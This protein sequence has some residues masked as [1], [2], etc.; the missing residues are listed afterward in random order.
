MNDIVC[1][2]CGGDVMHPIDDECPQCGVAPRFYCLDWRGTPLPFFHPRRIEASHIRLQHKMLHARFVDRH[3]VSFFRDIGYGF[4]TWLIAEVDPPQPSTL[5]GVDLDRA[6]SLTARRV[7]Y[8]RE[9]WVHK[10]GP[11][12]CPVWRGGEWVDVVYRYVS[13]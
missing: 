2:D 13:G 12:A 4:Q 5:F 3:G 8:E 10:Y 6:M 1:H 11:L 9:F 7:V